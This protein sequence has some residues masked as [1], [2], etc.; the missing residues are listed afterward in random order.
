VFSEESPPGEL[1]QEGKYQLVGNMLLVSDALNKG[2]PSRVWL[3]RGDL[4]IQTDNELPGRFRRV[5][6][7]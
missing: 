2:K 3:E 1:A 4:M 5:E 6:A 7:K